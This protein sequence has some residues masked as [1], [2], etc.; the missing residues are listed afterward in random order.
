MI[1]LPKYKAKKFQA[2][3]NIDMYTIPIGEQYTPI[4]LA[5]PGFASL[6]KPAAATAGRGVGSGASGRGRGVAA[7][8]DRLKAK[9]FA[10]DIKYAFDKRDGLQTLMASRAAADPDYMGS[11]QYINDYKEFQQSNRDIAQLEAIQKDYNTALKGKNIEGGA[12]AILGDEALVFDSADNTNK[13][14]NLQEAMSTV[15]KDGNKRYRMETIATAQN[16]RS[17]DDKFHGFTDEGKFLQ[18]LILN[19]YNSEDLYDAVD[20]GFEKAG[21]TSSVGT[22]LTMADGTVIDA[23]R[24]YRYV[25]SG[26]DIKGIHME[27]NTSDAD[28]LEAASKNMFSRVTSNPG[29]MSAYR[30]YAIGR[31]MEDGV[32][33][34]GMSKSQFNKTVQDYITKDI[35]SRMK[36]FLESKF[37][38]KFKE[39]TKKG[40][41]GSTSDPSKQKV[42]TWSTVVSQNAP[43]NYFNIEHGSLVDGTVNMG[44][45]SSSID[46]SVNFIRSGFLDSVSGVESYSYLGENLNIMGMVD[47]E[48]GKLNN[49]LTLVNGTKLSDIKDGKGLAAAVV[50]Q[51]Q[52]IQVLHRVP[53]EIDPDTNDVKVNLEY[54]QMMDLYKKT[55]D[56]A[57]KKAKLTKDD[58]GTQAFRDLKKDVVADLVAGD[59]SGR[60]ATFQKAMKDGSIQFRNMISFDVLVPSNL[61]NLGID[62]MANKEYGTYLKEQK[63]DATYLRLS[64]DDSADLYSDTLWV[65][66]DKIYLAKVFA[67]LK[68]IGRQELTKYFGVDKQNLSQGEIENILKSIAAEEKSYSGP[69]DITEL[70]FF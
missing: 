58:E 21:I 8:E 16:L 68:S 30:N 36:V 18:N 45:Q 63:E 4:K 59:T 49:Q 65:G 60:F 27:E 28:Q 12:Y 64:G 14:V 52:S 69:R 50:P 23:D 39:A 31:M 48:G 29:T 15:N 57:V 6:Y 53:V 41:S 5:T 24:F 61:E 55:L 13:I 26:F 66:T 1:L 34:K 42:H 19:S 51:N 38:S 22:K 20:D 35:G 67:P 17:R 43:D 70:P 3:G 46:D 54:L 44:I 47:G 7:K 10:N 32:D 56:G 2:G 37:S 11:A 9:G 25:D 40:K 33:T 62:L